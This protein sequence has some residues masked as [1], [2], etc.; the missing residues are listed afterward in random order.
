MAGILNSTLRNALTH[1]P[2]FDLDPNTTTALR[3]ESG[4]VPSISAIHRIGFQRSR[5]VRMSRKREVR[6]QYQSQRNRLW[7]FQ[8]IFSK[9]KSH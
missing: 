1:R 8:A 5:I 2:V 3:L 9:R 4:F 7:L 6:L